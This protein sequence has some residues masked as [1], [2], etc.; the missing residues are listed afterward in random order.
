MTE[1]KTGG[2]SERIYK[3]V[4]NWSEFSCQFNCPVNINSAVN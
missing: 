1:S 3:T 4:L 2:Y